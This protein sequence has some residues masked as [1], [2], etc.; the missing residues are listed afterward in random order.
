MDLYLAVV[1]IVL[2]FSSNP[3]SGRLRSSSSSHHRQTW[4]LST[5][6]SGF[7]RGTKSY[8]KISVSCCDRRRA[9][10]LMPWS[11]ASLLWLR[12]HKSCTA[13]N[14]KAVNRNTGTVV[15]RT[16]PKRKVVHHVATQ[17]MIRIMRCP[18]SYVIHPPT[19]YG[20]SALV[21]RQPTRFNPECLHHPP[22]RHQST[23]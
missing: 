13:M 19:G 14:K 10:A 6:T 23:P 4:I 15:I 21:A 22:S 17:R 18:S 3:L 20:D 8:V 5:G 2:G 1:W 16:G 7:A 11:G 9:W 12:E